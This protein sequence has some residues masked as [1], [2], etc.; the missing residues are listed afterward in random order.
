MAIPKRIWILAVLLSCIRIVAF[1]GV[2][3]NLRTDEAQ[4]QLAYLPFLVFDFPASIIYF[5]S[6]APIPLAEAIVGP[7]WWFALPIGIWWLVKGRRIHAKSR[8]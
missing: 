2:W 3:L 8:S 1:L 7:I 5:Q 6:W 4:W